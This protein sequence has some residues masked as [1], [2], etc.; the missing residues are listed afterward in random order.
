MERRCAHGNTHANLVRTLCDRVSRYSVNPDDRQ[1]HG[2]GAEKQDGRGIEA[3]PYQVVAQP[4]VERL[5]VVHGDLGVNLPDRVPAN[6]QELFR[7]PFDP[8]YKCHEIG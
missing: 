2:E 8:G 7:V 5:D 3:G 1:Q 4:L 6:G